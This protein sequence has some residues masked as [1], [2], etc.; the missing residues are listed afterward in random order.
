MFIVEVEVRCVG[1]T[2]EMRENEMC[3]GC[4]QGERG[5]GFG[6][7]GRGNNLTPN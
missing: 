6:R 5:I 2:V 7:R 4:C 3:C 1:D